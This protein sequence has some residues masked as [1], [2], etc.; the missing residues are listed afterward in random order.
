VGSTVVWGLGVVVFALTS[1][2]LVAVLA[3]VV[4]GAGNGLQQVLQR[5]LLLRICEPAFHGRV[6]G[7]LM[8][9]WGANV[10]GTLVGGGLAERFGVDG[11]VAASGALIVAVP[12]VV[13]LR[14][15]A[16]LRL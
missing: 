13:A 15:P 7:T 12:I 9:T 1:S 2:V 8:L 3:L 11:V 6:M 10:I 16:L 14:R 5:T 4:T